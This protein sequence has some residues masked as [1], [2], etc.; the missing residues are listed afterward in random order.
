MAASKHAAQADIGFSVAQIQGIPLLADDRKLQKVFTAITE[1]TEMLAL[2]SFRQPMSG[3]DMRSFLGISKKSLHTSV[4]RLCKVGVLI[5]V[6]FEHHQLYVI[7][8]EHTPL[9]RSC[10]NS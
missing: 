9:V 1:H 3:K 8:G 5:K 6:K 2:L 4:K 7:N 10:L